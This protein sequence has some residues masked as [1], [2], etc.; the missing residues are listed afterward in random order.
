MTSTPCQSAALDRIIS[1]WMVKIVA[2]FAIVI[3]TILTIAVIVRIP[4]REL[5]AWLSSPMMPKGPR[6]GMPGGRATGRSP[7]CLLR[8]LHADIWAMPARITREPQGRSEQRLMD[9][10]ELSSRR[11]KRVSDLSPRK[12][13]D[14]CES[15]I[16]NRTL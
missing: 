1:S 16:G 13:D 11:G 7:C 8:A 6:A 9:I 2:F 3:E 12:F 4:L 10:E 15:F 5:G 14:L